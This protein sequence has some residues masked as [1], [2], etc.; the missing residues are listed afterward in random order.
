MNLDRK[1]SLPVP[2]GARDSAL[3]PVDGTHNLRVASPAASLP[4]TDESI[5][6]P[7]AAPRTPLKQ[8]ALL[9]AIYV[10]MYGTVGVLVNV[11]HAVAGEIS[12]LFAPVRDGSPCLSG[13]GAMNEGGECARA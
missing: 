11:A 12:A 1:S 4:H 7:G 3:S 13:A 2:P 10:A 9:L 8:G 5:A 6:P